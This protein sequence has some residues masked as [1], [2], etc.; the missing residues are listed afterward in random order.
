MKIFYRDQTNTP[1]CS[2]EV[3]NPNGVIE[4]T[5]SSTY[6]WVDGVP[7]TYDAMYL[8]YINNDS[9]LNSVLSVFLNKCEADLK[10]P[11]PRARQ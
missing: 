1:L 8:S 4:A 7:Y 9:G 11:R 6:I 5:K 2:F 3:D 10:E